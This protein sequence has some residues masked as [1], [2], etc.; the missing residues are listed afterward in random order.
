MTN[1][2][3]LLKKIPTLEKEYP[4]NALLNPLTINYSCYGPVLN[5]FNPSFPLLEEQAT[6]MK[7]FVFG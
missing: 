4:W 3:S 5:G 1:V 7:K 6:L 2:F